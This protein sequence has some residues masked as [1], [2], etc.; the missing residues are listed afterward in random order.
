MGRKHRRPKRREYWRIGFI[1]RKML[2]QML[3]GQQKGC[4]HYCG[5]YVSKRDATLEHVVPQSQGGTDDLSNLVM[6]CFACNNKKSVEDNPQWRQQRDDQKRYL[7]RRRRGIAPMPH[8][9]TR[10]SNR[11][12]GKST[13]DSAQPDN[14]PTMPPENTLA[15]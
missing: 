3:W 8:A 1:R 12:S 5:K 13:S 9:S 15:A 6:A 7:A 4:C 14:D 11:E 10:A 2:R